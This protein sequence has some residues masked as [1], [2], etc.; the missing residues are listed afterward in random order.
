MSKLGDHHQH[1]PEIDK[2][3]DEIIDNPQN[4]FKILKKENLRIDQILP[5]D[6]M[7]EVLNLFNFTIIYLVENGFIFE[8]VENLIYEIGNEYGL[9]DCNIESDAPSSLK[10]YVIYCLLAKYLLSKNAKMGFATEDET[11]IQ[12]ADE[13]AEK[14]GVKPEYEE[15]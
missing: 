4:F 8:E 5:P 13:L 9:L 7:V 1:F 15:R 2:I 10:L 6:K 14:Y 11:M 12:Y 3:E